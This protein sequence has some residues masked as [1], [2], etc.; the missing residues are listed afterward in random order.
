MLLEMQGQ[1]THSNVTHHQTSYG[2]PHLGNPASCLAV[3]QISTK[4]TQRIGN[5]PRFEGKHYLINFQTEQLANRPIASS[6]SVATVLTKNGHVF[7]KRS[8]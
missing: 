8:I 5:M 2:R 4:F 7:Q 6:R 3:S 1:K